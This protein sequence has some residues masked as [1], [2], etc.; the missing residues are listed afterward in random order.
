MRRPRMTR[1]NRK[2][3]SRPRKTPLRPTH[4][5]RRRRQAQSPMSP[6]PNQAH[7][8]TRERRRPKLKPK[9][10]STPGRSRSTATSAHRWPW[11][12]ARARTPTRPTGQPTAKFRTHRIESWTEAITASPTPDCRNKT[13]PKSPFT[14]RRSTSTPRSAGWGT[15]TRRPAFEIRMPRRCRAWLLSHSTRT[16]TPA[17]ASRTLRSRWAPGGRDSAISRSTTPTCWAAFVISASN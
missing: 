12:S 6:R 10:H 9:S 11:A 14:P 13:G 1:P 2:R 8:T 16:S 4:P 15:G 7:Q 17:A 5:R 3:R